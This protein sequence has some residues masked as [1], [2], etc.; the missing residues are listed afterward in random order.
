[1]SNKVIKL[2]EENER[3]KDL[4]YETQ[5]T[6]IDLTPTKPQETASLLTKQVHS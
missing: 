2:Q 6:K 3:L 4:V 1:M 5:K